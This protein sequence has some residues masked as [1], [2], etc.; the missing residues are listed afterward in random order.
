MKTSIDIPDDTWK[1][2][3][4]LAIESGRDLKDIVVEALKIY[5]ERVEKTQDRKS[6]K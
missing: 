1:A 6:Q 3:K 5:L 2:A 4:H